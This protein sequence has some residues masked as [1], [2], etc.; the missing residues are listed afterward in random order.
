MIA[1][2]EAFEGGR[3][4]EQLEGWWRWLRQL[5]IRPTSI[6]VAPD[7]ELAL[8]DCMGPLMLAPQN[9]AHLVNYRGVAVQVDEA[10]APR[11]VELA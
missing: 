5:G 1:R 11:G 3:A 10:L 7:V 4:L 6:K 8:V 9:G 2:Y